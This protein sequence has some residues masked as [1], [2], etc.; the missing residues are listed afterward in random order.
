MEKVKGAALELADKLGA[1]ILATGSIDVI[2]DGGDVTLVDNSC[3]QLGS[4]TGTGCM[5]GGII[6]TFLAFD[7]DLTAVERACKFFK[8]CGNKAMTEK[9][10]GTFMV[11]LMDRLGEYDA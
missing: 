9:G 8:E 6:A 7:N 5:L 4:V 2:T 1:I 11:K 10:S 3:P